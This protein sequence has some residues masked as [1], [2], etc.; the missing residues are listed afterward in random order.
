MGQA[1]FCGCTA[2]GQRSGSLTHTPFVGLVGY[3]C[4]SSS[5]EGPERLGKQHQGPRGTAKIDHEVTYKA[6]KKLF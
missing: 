4:G 1:T 3:N 5:L 2:M 6:F